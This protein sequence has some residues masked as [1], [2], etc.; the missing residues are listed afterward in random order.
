M[1]SKLSHFAII[2]AKQ[3]CHKGT[4]GSLALSRAPQSNPCAHVWKGSPIMDPQE[5]TLTLFP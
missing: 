3:V 5:G 4:W 1:N 2:P